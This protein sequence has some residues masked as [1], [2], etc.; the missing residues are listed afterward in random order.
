MFFH[1]NQNFHM[2]SQQPQV[3]YYQLFFKP[4]AMISCAVTAKLIFVFVFSGFLI[5]R[6]KYIKVSSSQSSENIQKKKGVGGRHSVQFWILYSPPWPSNELAMKAKVTV[7]SRFNKAVNQKTDIK[8]PKEKYKMHY[9][10]MYGLLFRA[11]THH[12][13]SCS[14]NK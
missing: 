2:F 6:L 7:V 3:L 10:T 13:T 12:I 9:K 4:K 8:G 14:D 11:D 5:T 1:Q